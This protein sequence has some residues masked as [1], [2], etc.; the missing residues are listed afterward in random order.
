MS[1][2]FARPK[3]AEAEGLARAAAAEVRAGAKLGIWFWLPAI[4]LAIV[5]GCAIS[6]DWWPLP[7][8]DAIDLY[9][10]EA[11]PGTTGEVTI[12]RA[13]GTETET[14]YVYY[15]GA[16]TLGRD[17][18]TRLIFGARVSLVIGLLAPILGLMIGGTIGILSG[19]YRGPLE[20]IVVAVLDGILAFPALV[21]LLAI[22]F[23]FGSS[24]LNLTL[25]LGLLSIPYFARVARA[26][27]LTFAEREFVLAARAMG[28]RDS[29]I[30]VREIL[31]NVFLPMMVY[32]LLVIAALI[33]VEGTLSFLGVGLPAPTASWGGMIAEGKDSL[34]EAPHVSLIPTFVM[35]LTVLSFNLLGDTLR[36][37]SDPKESRL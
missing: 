4:W 34:E 32:A 28:A 33:V 1:D 6:A 27:T 8:P 15:L 19:Y 10:Q 35:F 24:L 16:D 18:V 2:A 20:S 25:A 12:A 14:A 21:L 13:D 11:P 29:Y 26:N 17:I 23:Y 22:T 7:A 37:L 30:I 31:P 3:P 9:N 5:A 36:N